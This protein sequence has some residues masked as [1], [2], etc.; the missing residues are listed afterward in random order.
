V[1]DA[2]WHTSA[3]IT[4]Y[5]VRTFPIDLTKKEQ[6]ITQDAAGGFADAIRSDYEDPG[7]AQVVEFVGWWWLELY[8]YLK[9]NPDGLVQNEATYG[10]VVGYTMTLQNG[11]LTVLP[12]LM[13]KPTGTYRRWLQAG[14]NTP[15]GA[16]LPEVTA[17]ASFRDSTE[18]II[19][20]PQIRIDIV[21]GDR[22]QSV[23]ASRLFTDEALTMPWRTPVAFDRATS[24]SASCYPEGLADDSERNVALL[25]PRHALLRP[26]GHGVGLTGIT[27]N[28][29]IGSVYA[30]V[31]MTPQASFDVLSSDV[32]TLAASLADYI[33]LTQKGAASGVA[34]LDSG[35]LIP[36]SQ[37][38]LLAITDTFVVASQA[39]MLALTAQVGDVAIRTDE[40]KTYILAASPASTLANWKEILAPGTPAPVT[41]VAGRTGAIVLAESDITGLVADLAAL[42][43]TGIV[44][45]CWNQENVLVAQDSTW[46]RVPFGFTITGAEIVADV[47]GSISIE[48]YRSTY[49]A[50]ATL[51][52]L[53][54]S[55]PIALSGAQK[56]QPALTGWTTAVAAGDYLM[57][58][59][60]GTPASVS[61]V[62]VTLTGTRS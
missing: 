55:A 20:P 46:L 21:M 35:G 6:V 12:T 45:E 34:T 18:Y 2:D 49:A 43:T 47:A 25:L 17:S 8:D 37:L 36:T 3:S 26:A 15:R 33:P 54:A 56:A 28:P 58:R 14:T 53:S 61:K 10:S 51:T 42:A 13:G 23:L 19:S 57:L 59:I 41:S 27:G 11:K 5:G 30:G 40:T 16:L 39:A 38:P 22:C 9:L 1:T 31:Q 44:A 32:A 29:V 62:T 52:K 24:G 60:T 7:L 50:W 48:L 4:K